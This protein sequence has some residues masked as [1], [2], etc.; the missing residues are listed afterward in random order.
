MPHHHTDL[1][2]E[3]LM[4]IGSN[5]RKWRSIKGLKQ[6]ALSEALDISSVSVSKIE[7]GKTNIP[8][9]RFCQIAIIL[10]VP[11]EKLFQ[12]PASHLL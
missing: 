11:V 3:K 2:R 8:I 10:Q 5:I 6:E 9:Y 7:T 4:E 1:K 12:D